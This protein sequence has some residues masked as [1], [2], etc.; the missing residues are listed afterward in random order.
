ML[1]I[2][3][4]AIALSLAIAVK[5][6][7]SVTVLKF[8]ALLLGLEGTVLLAS[9]LSPPYDQMSE[10]PKALHKLIVWSFTEARSLGYPISY[11]PVFFYGGLLL[12]AVSMILSVI[13][14]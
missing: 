9:A 14:G 10:K 13:G 7:W 3:L 4:S 6:Y 5:Y 11:N 12:L 8:I 1:T 2:V